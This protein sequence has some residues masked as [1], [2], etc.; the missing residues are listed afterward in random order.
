MGFAHK[1]RWYAQP[2]K[3]MSTT[4]ASVNKFLSWSMVHVSVLKALLLQQKGISVRFVSH[5]IL[6]THKASVEQNARI[7]LSTLMSNRLVYKRRSPA[8]YQTTFR[9]I[10]AKRRRV[11]LTS[12]L[13][14][15]CSCVFV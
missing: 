15:V 7:L 4:N 10:S 5:R 14:T 1:S 12:N 9:I 13:I 8:S 2:A 3:S 6:S 11:V